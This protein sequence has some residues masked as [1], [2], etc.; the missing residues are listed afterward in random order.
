[1]G[2]A[3]GEAE[4]MKKPAIRNILV[5]IDFSTM[6]IQAIAAAKRLAQRF[7]STVHLAN[8]QEPFYPTMF[9][10]TG[11]PVPVSPIET[12]EEVRKSTAQRLRTLAKANRL[13]GLCDA[14]IGAPV[15]DEICA[16]ARAIPADLIVMPTHGR[17][18]L[19]HVFL[20]SIA[21]RVVQHSPCP[22]FIVRKS[23]RLRKTATTLSIN[24]ILVPVDFSSCSL[25]ALNT[26]LPLPI[27][28][29]PG[30]S[31]SAALIWAMPTPL[32]ALLC[33]TFQLC[34]TQRA[35]L[36]KGKCE[37]SSARQNSAV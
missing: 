18:G 21:E 2:L 30:S 36:P 33:T 8:V 14:V 5:P 6:S 32:M 4:D 9:V 28:S 15:F 22:V 27:A 26:Q 35:R 29:R 10:G 19:K 25:E 34:K 7:R 11:G 12:V 3:S 31:S 17:T 23:K 20:G 16:I 37:N 1:M 13:T 24:T